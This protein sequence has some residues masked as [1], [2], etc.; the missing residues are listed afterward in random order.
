MLFVTNS[1]KLVQPYEGSSGMVW[2]FQ[3]R[4]TNHSHYETL[5]VTGYGRKDATGYD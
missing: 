5:C 3:N 4:R 2:R 1:V